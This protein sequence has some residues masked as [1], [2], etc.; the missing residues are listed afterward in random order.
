MAAFSPE[1][2]T[3]S[4]EMRFARPA[5]AIWPLLCREMGIHRRL[6]GFYG[7]GFHAFRKEHP[8]R[9]SGNGIAAPNRRET[10]QD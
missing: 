9:P 6:P 10:K 1:R 5:E 3:V 7:Y 4:A 8:S 2:L